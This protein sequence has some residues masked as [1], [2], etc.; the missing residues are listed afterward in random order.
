MDPRVLIVGGSLVGMATALALDAR[1]VTCRVVERWKPPVRGGTG[2]GVDRGLLSRVTGRDARRSDGG[3]GLLPV[4]HAH[5]EAAAW[6][7]IHDWLC[8]HV[9]AAKHINLVHGVKINRVGTEDD[10]AW[11]DAEGMRHLARVVVGADG[12]RSEVRRAV[13]SG[14]THGRWAGYVL[15]RGLAKET[16][17]PPELQGFPDGNGVGRT[18]TDGYRLIAY[19]VPGPDG[20]TRRCARAIAFAW[21]D[22]FRRDDLSRLG[23]VAGNEVLSSLA[24]DA[25]PTKLLHELRTLAARVWPLP[26]RE[27]VV[28]VID[29]G[30][31]FGTPI[32]EHVP[33]RLTHGR[34][35]LAGDA[36][37]VSTPA[38]G[39][40]LETGLLDAETFADALAE[41]AEGAEEQA[42]ANYELLRLRHGRAIALRGQ[43][44]SEAYVATAHER[45]LPHCRSL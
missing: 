40:G 12:Y 9:L 3:V 23:C 33:E 35:A 14:R 24:A 41:S 6:Q 18:T 25:M 39:G 16:W 28:A 7:D 19:P 36:A 30:E 27:A 17:L 1:G 34:L 15:W 42:L 43:A 44:W 20:G 5:G 37:H 26:W 31:L 11:A 10:H 32:V 45:R 4:I 38:L 13:G 8:A 2:L 29:R 22:P 21:Y